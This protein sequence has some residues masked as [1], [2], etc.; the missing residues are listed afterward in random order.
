MYKYL[1][2]FVILFFSSCIKQEKDVLSENN[3]TETKDYI[4]SENVLAI[5]YDD[6]L[7][8]SE[9][10]V[11]AE[12]WTSYQV[13]AVAVENLK[14]L[15]YDFF[16]KNEEQ[17]ITTFSELN[18]NIPEQFVTQPIKARLLVLETHMYRLKDELVFRPKLLKTDLKYL[19]EVFE[20]FSNLNLLINKKLEK[21][22]QIIFKPE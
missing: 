20:A 2:F 6:Y 8:A 12:S 19:K 17:F 16:T 14:T 21:E 1:L 11:Y 5:K 10:K 15:N 18:K 7:L 4:T 13:L 9:A 3:Q 22:A